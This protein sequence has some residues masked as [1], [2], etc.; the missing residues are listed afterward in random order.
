MLKHII[1]TTGF[2]LAA[3]AA[4]AFS[5]TTAS[6]V[7]Y[8]VLTQGSSTYT[9]LPLN[10]FDVM[11][12][13]TSN[14]NGQKAKV[15][16][17]YGMTGAGEN[18]LVSGTWR[19]ST[20]DKRN[21][22]KDPLGYFIGSVFTALSFPKRT[23]ALEHGVFSFLVPQNTVFGWILSSTDG[24]K[25]S[26]YGKICANVDVSPVPLPAGGLMLLG[27]FGGLAALRRRKSGAAV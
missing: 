12:A 6:A 10:G 14:N 17:V 13:L 27:A 25:G 3:A 21:A 20:T 24:K 26:S 2:A 7:T 5:T 11:F 16:E 1:R 4:L 18:L 15:A 23:P 19:F 9:P 8:G 22:S